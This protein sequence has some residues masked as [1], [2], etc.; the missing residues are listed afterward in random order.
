[1]IYADVYGETALPLTAVDGEDTVRGEG[2]GG[3]TV[4]VIH[5]KG[6]RSLRRV[7]KG[8]LKDS[9]APVYVAQGTSHLCLVHDLLGK[10]VACPCQCVGRGGDVRRRIDKGGG[11]FRGT[12][13]RLALQEY[14]VGE[15]CEPAL[16]C[17]RGTRALFLLVGAV[18]IL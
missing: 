13:R 2:T 17:D 1:M 7:V 9:S 18:K 16:A 4:A 10:N 6:I 8:C 5:R 14:R 15:R 3:L 11:V 12:A